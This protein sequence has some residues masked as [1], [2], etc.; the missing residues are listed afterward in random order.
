MFFSNYQYFKNKETFILTLLILFS[1][2]IR[3]PVIFQFGDLSLEHEWKILVNNLILHGTLSFRNL[4]GFLLPNL[5][6]PPLYAFYLYFFS[7]FNLV[8]Q[9]YI[10]LILF[11][12]ILLSSISVA[13]IIKQINFS[14]PKK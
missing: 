14:S 11:S 9:N 12:Q 5:F 7:I 6:M 10:L 1:I 13:F 4:D 8:E 2:F 3:I